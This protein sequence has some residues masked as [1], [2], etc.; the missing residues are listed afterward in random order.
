MIVTVT[1]VRR[2]RRRIIRIRI[3]TRKKL[4]LLRIQSDSQY[5][6]S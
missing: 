1:I 5:L 3:R 4:P 6:S 2:M